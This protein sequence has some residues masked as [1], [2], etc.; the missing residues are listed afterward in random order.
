[1]GQQINLFL[2]QERPTGCPVEENLIEDDG[3]NFDN[4]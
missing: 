1:M 4:R 2:T 3:N